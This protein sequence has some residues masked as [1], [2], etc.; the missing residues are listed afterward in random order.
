MNCFLFFFPFFF[1]S[2][3]CYSR[4]QGDSVDALI[5]IMATISSRITDVCFVQQ[6]SPVSMSVGVKDITFFLIIIQFVIQLELFVSCSRAENL[7]TD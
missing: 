4:R 2:T 5:R 3:S 1:P 7:K 6:F